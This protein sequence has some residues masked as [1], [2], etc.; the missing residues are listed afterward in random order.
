MND[1]VLLMDSY[2]NKEWYLLFNEKVFSKSIKSIDASIE[3]LVREAI[4]NKNIKI[5]SHLG[6][7]AVK[8]HKSKLKCFNEGKTVIVNSLGGWRFIT[9]EI[10]LKKIESNYFPQLNTD[11]LNG[12][13]KDNGKFIECD[14]GH[15]VDIINEIQSPDESYIAISNDINGRNS[16]LFINNNITEAQKEFLIKNIEKLNKAQIDMLIEGNTEL[17]LIEK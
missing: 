5:G 3:S 12:I 16:S 9:D 6:G 13:L 11:Y 8:A 17:N 4:N 2:G 15:H 14:Y 1:Y 10:I 7:F